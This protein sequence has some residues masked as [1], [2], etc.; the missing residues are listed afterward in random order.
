MPTCIASS[1]H[2]C[3]RRVLRDVEHEHNRVSLSTMLAQAKKTWHGAKLGKPDWG[4]HSH[5]VA[6]G[7]ELRSEGLQFHLILNAYWKPLDFE[8]P[9]VAVGRSWQRWI[10]TALESPLDI[11][12]WQS[13]PPVAGDSY[14]IESH[15]VVMLFAEGDAE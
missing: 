2:L 12:P 9:K 6:F 10:D 1:S 4:D 15:S 11:S 14:R 13:A 8:L 5:S 7:G 3:A